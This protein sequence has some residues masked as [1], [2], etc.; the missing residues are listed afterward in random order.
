MTV[1]VPCE[2]RDDVAVIVPPVIWLLERVEMKAVAA[3]MSVARRVFVVAVPVT[4][5][6][7]AVV[8]AS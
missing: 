2:A 8:V 3:S 7:E 6:V 4:V 1:R 5:K